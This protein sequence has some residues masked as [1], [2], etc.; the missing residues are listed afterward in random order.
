MP[1]TDD[2]PSQQLRTPAGRLETVLARVEQALLE[3][4]AV[5]DCA[6]MARAGAAGTELLGYVVPN[7]PFQAE[8]VLAGVRKGIEDLALPLVCVPVSA[9]PLR[10]DGTVDEDALMALPLADAATAA[11]CREVFARLPTAASVEIREDRRRTRLLHVSDLLETWKAHATAEAPSTAARKAVAAETTAEAEA[12]PA[13]SHGEPLPEEPGVPATLAEALRRAASEAPG[14]GVIYV[15]AGGSDSFQSYPALLEAGERVLGGLRRAGLKVGDP[16]LFQL[17]R[18]ED[19]LAAFWGCTLGGFV[20]VPV[21]IAPTYNSVNGTVAKLHN[22]WQMLERPIVVASDG[23]AAG[24]RGIS[25]LLPAEGFAVHAIGDLLRGSRDHDWHPSEPDD[26]AILLLTSGSTGAPKAVMQS[27]RALLARSAATRRMN[28][29]TPQDVSVNWLPLDHVGGIVMFHLRDVTVPCMQVHAP[30]Q[31]MLADPL[32]W[33][34][35]LDR[36]RATAT[37]APNFAYGLVNAQA[38]EVARRHWDLSSVRFILNAGEA[39]VSQTARR[40][41]SLLA[42]HGL[43]AGAMHPSWGMSETCSAVTFVRDYSLERTSDEDLFVEVGEPVPG[44]SMRIV[45][46]ENQ[47]VPEGVVGRLQVRGSSVLKGYFR[48]PEANRDSFSDDGWFITGDLGIIRNRRMTITGREKDVII[49]NG[50]NFHGHEIEKVVEDIPGIEASFT[51]AFAIREPGSDTDRLAICFSPSGGAWPGDAEMAGLLRQVRSK[52]M[53]S[54]GVSTTYLVPVEREEIPKTSIGKIQR[55]QLASRLR[56]G[57]FDGILKRVDLA[58]ETANTIPDWFYRKI[59][60]RRQAVAAGGLAPARCLIFADVGGVGERLAEDLAGRGGVGVVVRRGAALARTDAGEYTIDP[61]DAA[62][63]VALLETVSADGRVDAVAHLWGCDADVEPESPAAF[64]RALDSGLLSVLQVAQAL[65]K[66]QDGAGPTR[67]VVGTRCAQRVAAGEAILTGTDAAAHAAL[68]G[69]AKTVQ[70]ELPWVTCCHVDLDATPVADDARL[71]AAE[72]TA[73]PAESVVAYRGG[74]RWAPRL[75]NAALAASEKQP[76]PFEQGGLYL[77]TGGL[78]GIA[79]E[80]AR[81]LVKEYGARLLLVGRTALDGLDAERGKALGELQS[82]AESRA[83]GA[84]VRYEV[85][86]VCDAEALAGAVASAEAQ[87]GVALGGVLHL[88]GTFRERLI[89]DETRDDFRSAIAPKVQG[90][91][92]VI[93][94]LRTRPE[95]FLV[96]FSSV[97]GFFGGFSSGAYAAANAFLDASIERERA[98]GRRAISLAWSLWDEVGMSR[99]FAMKELSRAQGYIPVSRAQG[100]RSFLAALR[101]R[102]AAIWIGLDAGGPQVRRHLEGAVLPLQKLVVATSEA[103]RAE[104]VKL[105]ERLPRDRYGCAIAVDVVASAEGAADAASSA[106]AAAEPASALERSVARIWA[107]ALGTE[108]DLDGNFFDLGGTSV[109]AAQVYRKIHEV[110]GNGL[111]MT[112]LFQFPTVRT[113]C[114][115]LTAGDS[116]PAGRVAADQDRGRSSRERMRR[117]RGGTGA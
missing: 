14:K 58:L 74:E 41:L 108:I 17:D 104:A 6:V 31:E 117:R 86:D 16:V 99:G 25:G 67:L 19:F 84:G 8:R 11:Q 62:Q 47:V 114:E 65:Q 92:A 83:P 42:P 38:D 12:V 97:N 2:K 5:G 3:Q 51:A 71:L 27:H 4:S 95:A 88:A 96:G 105:A 28:R 103:A 64:D 93:E 10:E 110:V 9:I 20:P 72:I 30:T 23:L 50:A 40:F 56:A 34:D 69:F 109:L 116:R 22:A 53:A 90:T 55:A 76:P 29:F 48:N 1:V 100:L 79:L 52:V 107:E 61:T 85:A 101:S 63:Y 68:S 66:V 43:R 106:A 94:V 81:H 45:D 57:E 77:L 7:G 21:S 98:R 60:R 15:H 89:A 73:L 26:L 18:A 36:Y 91:R 59:W 80:V 75:A 46:R 87:W 39:I 78:G 32:Q 102:E 111:T 113:L 112:D 49:I 37:W 115:H 13:I 82:L 33:I 70:Q 44:F 35:W 54:I 24:V